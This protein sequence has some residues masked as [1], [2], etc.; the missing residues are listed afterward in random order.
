MF[1]AS[2]GRNPHAHKQP[3]TILMR[4]LAELFNYL[5]NAVQY[6]KESLP[7]SAIR[8]PSTFVARQRFPQISEGGKS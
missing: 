7:D 3:L 1:I 6:L 4:N 8:P 5:S 2:Q